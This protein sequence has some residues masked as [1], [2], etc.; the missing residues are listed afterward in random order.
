MLSF[1]IFGIPVRV[2]PWFWLTMVLIGGGLQANSSQGMLQVAMFVVAG[3]ISIMVHEL[4]H[5]L[6]IRKYKLPTSITLVAFGGFASYPSGILDRKQSFIVSAA[7]PAYQLILGILMYCILRWGP[8]PPASLLNILIY[9]LMVISIL[10]AVFNCVPVY[11]MDGGQLL[12]AVLGPKRQHFVF[13]TGAVCALLIGIAGYRYFHSL[14][15]PIFMGFLA[16][17]NWQDYQKTRP[18]SR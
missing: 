3:F 15:L 17:K 12:A 7:G 16:W 8:V 5:A 14:I 9:Y 4:G 1:T 13:L 11:P 10:W 6:S 18:Q 2:E